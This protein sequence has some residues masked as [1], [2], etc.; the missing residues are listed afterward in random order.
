MEE[1]RIKKIL[2]ELQQ[3][4]PKY[5]ISSL[6]TQQRGNRYLIVV[7]GF[8]ASGNI[9]DWTVNVVYPIWWNMLEILDKHE[10]AMR[11]LRLL[12]IR[13]NQFMLHSPD[14]G[15]GS[16]FREMTKPLHIDVYGDYE[17]QHYVGECMNINDAL[18]YLTTTQVWF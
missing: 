4:Y 16:V 11:D 10:G 1:L 6:S 5:E 12:F 3:A 7:K 13:D 8:D 15:F 18:E 14:V 2:E 17:R 9:D